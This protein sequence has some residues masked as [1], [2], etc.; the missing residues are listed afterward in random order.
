MPVVQE[1]GYLVLK[2]KG[3]FNDGALEITVG[4][5]LTDAGQAAL[6]SYAEASNQNTYPF[7]MTLNGADANFDTVYFGAIVTRF[8]TQAGNANAVLRAM[9]TLEINTPIYT[10]AA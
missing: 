3:G 4:Q 8:R 1:V 9:I 2:L 5:D 6:K 10:G 7:K